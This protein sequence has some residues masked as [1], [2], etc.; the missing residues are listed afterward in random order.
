MWLV[1]G[2]NMCH[3]RSEYLIHGWMTEM[4]K[5]SENIKNLKE[6]QFSGNLENFQEG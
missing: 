5:K 3:D 4:E 2:E 6:K 1:G